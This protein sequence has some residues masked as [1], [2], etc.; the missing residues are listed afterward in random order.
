VARRVLG[1]HEA[2]D[3]VVETAIAAMHAAGTT[4]HGRPIEQVGTAVFSLHPIKNVTTGEGGVVCTDDPAPQTEVI[5]PGF[6]YNLPDMNAA[7]ASRYAELLV[8]VDEVR[9]LSIP[10]YPLTHA[11]HLYIV[12][13]DT[14]RAGMSRAE[15]MDALKRHNVGTG[16]HF[17][18]AHQHSY[19]RRTHTLSRDLP[20][21]DWNSD[22]VYSLP[23]FPDMEVG[24]VDRV[25]R[26]IRAVL[27]GG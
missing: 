12:R 2:V 9:P 14:D 16:I 24:D 18:A 8:A 17:R 10:E 22:R 6:K 3:A 15:F 5:E 25:V 7:L 26:A 11:W 13:L 4:Y 27:S 20:H 19:Y 1:F 23:L 21:I